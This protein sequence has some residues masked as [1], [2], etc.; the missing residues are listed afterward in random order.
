MLVAGWRVLDGNRI[1][2]FPESRIRY[3]LFMK[4]GCLGLLRSESEGIMVMTIEV[5]KICLVGC[6]LLLLLVLS[7]GCEKK[8]EKTD[9]ISGPEMLSVYVV[10]VLSESVA[11]NL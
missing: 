8:Q 2:F 4:K 7:S 9:E 6:Y 5:K 11:S 1:F 3:L 10:V